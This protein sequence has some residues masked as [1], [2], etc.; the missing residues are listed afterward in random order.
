M[1]LLSLQF[2]LLLL[3]SLAAYYSI[4][5]T[6]PEAQWY[7]LLAASLAFYVLAGSWQTL[8]LLI[9][10]SADIWAGGLYLAHLDDQSK[11]ERKATK[12]R[13]ARKA[14]KERYDKRRWRAFWTSLVVPLLILGFFKYLNVILFNFGAAESPH[15]LGILLPLGISFYTFQSIGYL[16]DAYNAKYAPEQNYLRFLLFVSWFPQII[17]GPIGRYDQLSGQLFAPRHADSYGMRRGLLRLGYGLFKKLTIAN[18]LSHNVSQIFGNVTPGI[19]GSVV[20]YGVLVYSIQ[21]YADFSG[22]IDIV[23]GVSELF[24]VEMAQNFRQPYFSVSLADFWRRWHMSLGSWMRDY[25]F[26]PIALTKPMQSFGKWAKKRLGTHAGRTLPACVANILVFL[27]VGIWH[28]ADWHYVGWGLYNGIIVAVSDLLSPVFESLRTRLRVTDETRWF[29]A[30]AIVRTF[31]V[32][33]VGRY[34]DCVSSL[35]DSFTCLRA[36]LFNF[37]PVPFKTALALCKV[38]GAM[39][40]GISRIALVA[41]T[42]V[43]IISWHYERGT[44]VRERILS[45]NPLVRCCLYA[46]LAALMLYAFDFTANGGGGFLYAN[47]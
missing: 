44:D 24:G 40:F 4:G 17:Q 41:C 18:V 36:T 33:N 30:F 26:Y 8:L 7:V 12:D 16:I 1:E 29:R 13:K 5:R 22:G 45:W 6:K 14:I 28:G 46:V 19:P 20:L 38:D 39:L 11:A 10:T 31:C 23:E 42:V 32:V 9:L 15:S 43:A 2:V 47:F 21:M 35:S 3:A 34:F 25:I 27:L 37:A